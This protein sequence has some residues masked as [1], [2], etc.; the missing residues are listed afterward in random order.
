MANK[1]NVS[2]EDKD[3]LTSYK[4]EVDNYRT[5]SDLLDIIDEVMVSYVDEQDE[6]L[7]DFLILEKIYDRIYDA[8]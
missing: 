5:L 7:E 4:I 3:T 8:N 6:P 1:I 2:Q